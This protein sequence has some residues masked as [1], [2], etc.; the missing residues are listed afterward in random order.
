MPKKI[1]NYFIVIF[2]IIIIGQAFLLIAKPCHAAFMD[3]IKCAQGDST[4]PPQDCDLNDFV[5]M[6]IIISNY[7]LGITGSL[8]LCAFIYGG[9]VMLISGG[10]SEKVTQAKSIIIGAV[11]GLVIVFASYIIIGFVF[12]SMG[13]NDAWSNS[14]W[15]S[16]RAGK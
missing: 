6:A 5:R 15:F 11:I 16:S 13:I 12:K 10:S 9:V 7:L 14:S 1:K 8:A 3:T 2:S 4:S